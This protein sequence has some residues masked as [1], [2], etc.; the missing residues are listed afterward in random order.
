MKTPLLISFSGLLAATTLATTNSVSLLLAGQPTT[1]IPTATEL[2]ER[3]GATQDKLW[4][5]FVTTMETIATFG[6][7]I[8]E[9]P[10]FR[11]GEWHRTV[12]IWEYRCDSERGYDHVTTLWDGLQSGANEMK[13]PGNN[14]SLWDGKTMYGYT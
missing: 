9:R 8:R 4:T 11:P 2:I 1:K 14:Y 6:G 5:S 3:L 13:H 10:Q 12:K 7:K